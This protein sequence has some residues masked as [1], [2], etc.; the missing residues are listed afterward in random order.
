MAAMFADARG[1][2]NE[3]R[4]VAGFEVRPRDRLRGDQALAG[5]SA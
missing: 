5:A 2:T 4:R 3:T 1:R